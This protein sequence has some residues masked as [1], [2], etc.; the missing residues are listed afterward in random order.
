MM[1]KLLGCILCVM[2]LLFLS[3]PVAAN[4]ILPSAG[5]FGSYWDGAATNPDQLSNSG[6]DAQLSWLE[7]GLLGG[8]DAGD[9]EAYFNF[10]DGPKVLDEFNVGVIGWDYAIVKTGLGSTPDKEGWYAYHNDYG[11]D[12][13]NVPPGPDGWEAFPNGVSHIS[14]YGGQP[15]P[16]PATMLLLGTGLI[17]LAGAGRKKLFK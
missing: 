4:T 5:G 7:D 12:L 3:T 2:V 11:D 10:D 17:G 15:V 16:E 14:V 9:L 1:K 13:L 6:D 8:G